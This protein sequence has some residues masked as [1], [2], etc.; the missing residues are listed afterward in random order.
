MG[1][2]RGARHLMHW[3]VLLLA[4]SVP[5]LCV[6]FASLGGPAYAQAV[7]V[8]PG[9]MVV[10]EP[11]EGRVVALD[12]DNK[13]R[14][15]QA[16][17]NKPT[18][19][20][21]LADGTVL[22]AESGTNRILG[23]GGRYA[24]GSEVARDLP[25]PQAL[26]T[27][28]DGTPYL[29]LANGQLGRLDLAQPPGQRYVKITDG[30]RAPMGLAER[31]GFL[32]VAES[33]AGVVTQV[34]ATGEKTP[35]AGPPFQ[36]PVGVATGP[37]RTLF[38]AD[39]RAG[40]VF[41]IDDAGVRT[42]FA[43]VDTPQQIAVDPYQPGP[44]T[45]YTVTV[46]TKGSVQ[47]FDRDRNRVY[48]S[49]DVNNGR[50]VAAVPAGETNVD[51]KGLEVPTT[52]ARTAGSAPPRPDGE[53]TAGTT[54]STY[55]LIVSLAIIGGLVIFAV[56]MFF[57]HEPKGSAQAG[58]EERPLDETV[59]EVFGPCANQE[60]ELAEVEGGLH[61]IVTQREA[62]EKSAQEA[63]RRVS[64]ARERANRAQQAKQKATRARA[65]RAR[66][67]QREPV[68]GLRTEE[69]RLRSKG[70]HG[71]LAAFRAG[72]IDATE[73]E[74][75]WQQLGEAK[76]LE[77]VQV[78]GVVVSSKGALSVDEVRA[79]RAEEHAR[80]ELDRAEHERREAA[81]EIERLREREA[82]AVRRIREVRRELDA[83]N[84]RNG[85]RS[86]GGRRSARRNE[87]AEAPAG[88]T[89]RR[90]A[91][92]TA[93]P[94]P[95]PVGAGRARTGP[96][97]PMASNPF[98]VVPEPGREATTRLRPARD[99]ANGSRG[100]GRPGGRADRPGSDR[101]A[102]R[103]APPPP[104]APPAWPPT[105]P[106]SSVPRAPAPPPPPP[107]P[108]GPGRR[109]TADAVNG[110]TWDAEPGPTAPS[111]HH[112]VIAE[113]LRA[114]ERSRSED[115][116]TG[117]WPPTPWA[118]GRRAQ[119]TGPRPTTG[120][121]EYRRGRSRGSS[122]GPPPRNGWPAD[123]PP[124]RNGWPADPPPPRNGWPADPPATRNGRPADRPATRNGDTHDRPR[125][126]EPP[127][128]GFPAWAEYDPASDR[129]SPYLGLHVPEHLNGNGNGN[130][131]RPN[132]R[133]RPD[134]PP[135]GP[136]RGR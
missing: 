38:V 79:A 124:P 104:P 134:E 135:R 68:P 128:L 70:G 92:D 95:V 123:P 120:P 30:L 97:G 73:L 106:R 80:D 127:D 90:P 58:F 21:A 29:T 15:I 37:G 64:A 136:R 91:G 20:A 39:Q 36:L 88:R 52:R 81:R 75:R 26:T 1:A 17:L 105:P 27:G 12:A 131:R 100:T 35:V 42:D 44:D 14:A 94:A 63:N 50:G 89:A 45:A 51:G 18:G 114:T 133:R 19:V 83:C 101:G 53:F 108:A 23:Y 102:A 16:G 93:K 67:G 130:G 5:L 85:G 99:Q 13:V 34:S 40:K 69:L 111:G 117:A 48:T 8:A 43:T 84:Q 2:S 66:A 24:D 9:D 72:E 3:A 47:R 60:V 86:R 62:A 82:Q 110:F 7:R 87:E 78:I 112:D 116:T 77:C 118:E 28:S 61:A 132:G 25:S 125:S 6:S 129:P 121:P 22:V 103:P 11:D 10:A 109:H 65:A 74:E 41:K 119:D 122:P 33:G 113:W 59:L 71:A 98:V 4:A 56:L 96:P 31:G 126:P 107:R 54:T 46:A 32:Y 55:A 115:P 49:A 57:I 76:A